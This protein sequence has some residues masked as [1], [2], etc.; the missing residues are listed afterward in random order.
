MFSRTLLSSNKL[1]ELRKLKQKK[2]RNQ[3]NYILGE[4]FRLFEAAQNASRL[5]I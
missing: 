4:G 1:K 3:K 2:Y 5:A